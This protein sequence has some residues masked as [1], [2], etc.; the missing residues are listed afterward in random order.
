MA[1]SRTV[2]LPLSAEAAAALQVGERVLLSGVLYGARDQAHRRFLEALRQGEQLPVDLLGQTIYYVGPTPAPPGLSCGAA[3]PTTSERMDAATPALLDYG[4]R[5]LIGKG[6][7]GPEV[8]EAIRRNGAVYLAATG[9]AAAL[10]GRCIKEMTAVA[11]QELGTEAVWR[12]VVEDFPATVA[13]D[14]RG[15]NIYRLG[16]AAYRQ[17]D[18]PLP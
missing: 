6:K 7:R 13:I 16:P 11:Y 18:R 8:V 14:S 4:V 3:G 5:A 10:I 1:E 12:M 17:T 2:R 9:G 15:N